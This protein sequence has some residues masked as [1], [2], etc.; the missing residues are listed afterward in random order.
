MYTCAKSIYN[1]VGPYLRVRSRY[2][3]IAVNKVTSRQPPGAPSSVEPPIREL[4]SLL[5]DPPVHLLP[6][7]AVE[8]VRDNLQYR[9]DL[10]PG[11][12]PSTVTRH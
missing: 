2:G 12:Q 4:I 9:R 1:I 8:H 7:V 6:R 3:T 11:G 10:S 5:D